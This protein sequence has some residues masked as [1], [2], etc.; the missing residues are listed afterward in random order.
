MCIGCRTIQNHE[1]MSAIAASRAGADTQ[2]ESAPKLMDHPLA[3]ASLY[4]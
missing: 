1:H 3:A 2:R 4:H